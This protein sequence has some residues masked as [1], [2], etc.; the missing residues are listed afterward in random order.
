LPLTTLLGVQEPLAGDVRG[1]G[2]AFRSGPLSADASSE[3]GDDPSLYEA[4][5]VQSSHTSSGVRV[6]VVQSAELLA[7]GRVE[8]IDIAEE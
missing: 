6:R 8:P 2:P 7:R 4:G 1:V 3:A 5:E